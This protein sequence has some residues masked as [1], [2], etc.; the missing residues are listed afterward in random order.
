MTSLTGE[1]EE[2]TYSVVLH[3]I[4]FVITLLFHSPQKSK[5][6]YKQRSAGRTH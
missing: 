3:K 4:F 5:P 2:I 1:H 6:R